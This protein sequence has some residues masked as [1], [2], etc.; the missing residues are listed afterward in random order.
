MTLEMALSCHTAQ[1]LPWYEVLP[2]VLTSCR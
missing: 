2:E 1:Y